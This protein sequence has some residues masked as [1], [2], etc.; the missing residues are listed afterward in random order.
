MAHYVFSTQLLGKRICLRVQLHYLVVKSSLCA[1]TGS[2]TVRV[3]L[4][5]SFDNLLSPFYSGKK[6]IRSFQARKSQPRPS[7][8]P[9]RTVSSKKISLLSSNLSNN[10]YVHHNHRDKTVFHQ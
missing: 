8:I 7:T 2:K 1:E 9:L 5:I 3:Y 10:V 6:L 4:P